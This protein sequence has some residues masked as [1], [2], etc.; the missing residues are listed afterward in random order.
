MAT[1]GPYHP[2]DVVP[3]LIDRCVDDPIAS[4]TER[5]GY[6]ISRALVADDQRAR[7]W[8]GPE[9]RLVLAPTFTDTHGQ[10]C[11]GPFA[12][13]LHRIPPDAAPGSL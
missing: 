3:L 11:S 2:G 13:Y 9:G 4:Q 5:S 8:T 6:D 7:D 12:T 1:A 10:G